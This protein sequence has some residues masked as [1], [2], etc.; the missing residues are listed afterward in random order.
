MNTALPSKQ[1]GATLI[2]ALVFLVVLTI[3]GITAMQFS[4]LEERMAG[5]SQSRNQVFQETQNSI[6][7]NLLEL[8]RSQVGRTPLLNAM[9]A[10]QYNDGDGNYPIKLTEAEREHLG[11]PQ[12]TTLAVNAND[13]VIPE[14]GFSVIRKTHNP[15]L[16]DYDARN[17]SGQI[18]ECS[19][20]EIQT[21]V[22]LDNG[23]YSDQS[24]G[25][26][27]ENVRS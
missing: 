20:F 25:I 1:N 3:A 17:A 6:Q 22:E 13:S 18:I 15:T 11:L 16:C 10:G 19:K 27:F 26:V 23:A 2:V 21:R 7:L 5:N 14:Q 12:T 8:N 4:T 9:N 24:Q